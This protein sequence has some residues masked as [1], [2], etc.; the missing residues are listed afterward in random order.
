MVEKFKKVQV[1]FTQEQYDLLQELKGEL[2][3]TDADVVRNIILA[4]LTEKSFISTTLKV[5]MFG[6]ENL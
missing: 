2:G 6:K 3:G 4:W 5:K 1:N